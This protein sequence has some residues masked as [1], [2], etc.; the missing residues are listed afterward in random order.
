MPQK[1]FG[2]TCALTSFINA[3]ADPLF[4]LNAKDCNAVRLEC[5]AACPDF[6]RY[7]FGGKSGW[8]PLH[9]VF[10]AARKHGWNAKRLKVGSAFSKKSERRVKVLEI[11][12]VNCAKGLLVLIGRPT[13]NG[14]L[15]SDHVIAIRNNVVYDGEYPAPVPIALYD[16]F[17]HARRMYELCKLAIV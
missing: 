5:E 13:I 1:K 7:Q 9:V 12:S 3:R 8:W 14:E 15:S 11:A 2:G 10:K 4:S 16:R 17:E 6:L